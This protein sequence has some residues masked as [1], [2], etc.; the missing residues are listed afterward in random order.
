[1]V[2]NFNLKCFLRRA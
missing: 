1:M 2:A